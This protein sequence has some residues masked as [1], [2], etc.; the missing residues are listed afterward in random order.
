MAKAS[1]TLNTKTITITRVLHAPRAKVWAVWTEPKHLKKWWGPKDFTA[2][3]IKTDL[4]VGGTFVYCMHGPAG[5]EFDKDMWSGGEFKEIVP[6]EKIVATDYFTD[7]DGNWI[8]PKEMG[9]PGE[10]P[11]KMLVTV[12]FEDAGDGKTK[13]TLVHEGHP[14]E[15]AEMAEAGWNQSLDKFEAALQS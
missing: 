9:M 6:M 4:R 5:T 14:A 11:E 13:L 15:M 8:S 7:K 1:P 2:P 12:T 10:W 3:S